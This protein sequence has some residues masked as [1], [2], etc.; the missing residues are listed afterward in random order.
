MKKI[1]E[2]TEDEIIK[3]YG[4]EK[5]D[6][7]IWVVRSANNSG[8]ETTHTTIKEIINDWSGRSWEAN[9][10]HV[11]VRFNE[12]YGHYLSLRTIRPTGD[13]LKFWDTLIP[14]DEYFHV[15]VYTYNDKDI[16]ELGC[17]DMG[18][19][20]KD[21]KINIDAHN[22]FATQKEG[23]MNTDRVIELASNLSMVY[24]KNTYFINNSNKIVNM[25]QYALNLVLQALEFQ[26][27]NEHLSYQSC[28]DQIM[29]DDEIEILDY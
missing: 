25:N 13:N 20:P 24:G 1:K 8:Y 27:E 26:S 21:D 3:M 6:L 17:T 10:E 11:H 9:S 15:R 23:S 2:M 18:Y 16:I 29:N 7:T 4:D 5:I 14:N 28:I 19:T 22:V 12:D